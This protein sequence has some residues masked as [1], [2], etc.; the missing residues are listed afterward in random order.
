MILYATYLFSVQ[1]FNFILCLVQFY[2]FYKIVNIS[3]CAEMWPKQLRLCFLITLCWHMTH[4]ALILI[5]LSFLVVENVGCLICMLGPLIVMFQACLPFFLQVGQP[6]WGCLLYNLLSFSIGCWTAVKHV[7][8]CLDLILFLLLF[9]VN[10]GSML[11]MV[12]LFLKCNTFLSAIHSNQCL[13]IS[14][15]WLLR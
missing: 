11:S 13:F 8:F 9:A 7:N 4:F 3:K 1:C 6:G 15:Y 2:F 10:I 12:H 14:F 5:A